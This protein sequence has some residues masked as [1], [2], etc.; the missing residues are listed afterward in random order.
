VKKCASCSKD[1]PDAALHCVFCGAKQPPTQAPQGLAKTVMGYSAS[2]MIEQMKQQ[3]QQGPTTRPGPAAAPPQPPPP[4]FSPPPSRPQPPPV[5]PAA[6]PPTMAEPPRGNN[7][8]TAYAGP[9][10]FSPSK[11]HAPSTGSNAP[12]MYANNAPQPQPSY[13]APS[14]MGSGPGPSMGGPMAR[15]GPTPSV[16]M[17]HNVAPAPVGSPPYLAS[18]TAARS[19]RPIEPWKDSLRFQMF[20]WGAVLL[21]VFAVPI[22][23]DPLL[24]YWNVVAD[25]EG[26][27]KLPPL[28]MASVGLLAIVIASIPM[29]PAPRG[30]IAGVL[31]LVGV[32]MPTILALVAGATPSWQSLVGLLVTL[33]LIPGLLVRQEYRDALLPRILV[34]VG[35]LAALLPQLIPDDAGVPLVNL[36]KVL[37][38]ADVKSM[39][40]LLVMLLQIVLI[41]LCLLVWLPAPSTAM[42]KVFAWLLILWPLVSHVT[43]LLLHADQIVDAL[44]ESPNLALF[45]PL[46]DQ[47]DKHAAVMPAGWAVLAAYATI[48]SY[49]LATVFGKQLE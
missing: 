43:A 49:G 4:A 7:A 44:K 20:T 18:Q 34:T 32:V 28:V 35:V 21:A 36:F 9:G 24:G 25:G 30:V 27:I 31:G 11:P 39:V 37:I 10:G 40:L 14:P 5:R 3:G 15:S 16:P 42:A 26:M 23:I 1:L 17:P 8:P 12:T 29:S 45:G 13:P 48:T 2:E 41:V 19:G 22:A 6:L 33:A 47:A 46:M 38:D